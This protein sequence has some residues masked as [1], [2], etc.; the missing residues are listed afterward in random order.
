MSEKSLA[1]H[2]ALPKI[3]NSSQQAVESAHHTSQPTLLR[4]KA[5]AAELDCSLR[6]V[7]HLQADGMPC[8]FIGRSRRFILSEVIAWLK[9]RGGRS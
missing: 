4:R 5:L 8:V 3:Q 9:R 6:T 7:D 1:K 2:G